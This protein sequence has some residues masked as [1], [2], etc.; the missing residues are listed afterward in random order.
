MPEKSVIE[1]CC[2]EVSERNFDRSIVAVET[3]WRRICGE[4]LEK[5]FV[6]KCCRD[7]LQRD[8]LCIV[9][10]RQALE[11]GCAEKSLG[12]VLGEVFE[13]RAVW[14]GRVML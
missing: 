5:T 14:R 10:Y 13:Q 12:T 6:E 11:T 2:R 8:V 7:V 1:T 9:L 4:V 3:C